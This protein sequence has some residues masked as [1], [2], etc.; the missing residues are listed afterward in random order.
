MNDGFEREPARVVGHIGDA[1]RQPGGLKSS[2]GGDS[3]GGDMEA[4]IA[5]L[6][7]HYEQMSRT[8]DKLETS[9]DGLKTGQ[10]T[11]VERTQH[12]S[13]KAD[14]ERIATRMAA[15]IVALTAAFALAIRFLP[16]GGN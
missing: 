3:S 1:G 10:A 4:R 8:L 2:D 16:I 14:L 9:V 15:I 6:E 11:L 5:K 13:T 12:L 7:A